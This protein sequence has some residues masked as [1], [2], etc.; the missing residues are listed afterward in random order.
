LTIL[1]TD[2]TLRPLTLRPAA[3]AAFA[4]RGNARTRRQDVTEIGVPDPV[5]PEIE[6]VPAVDPVPGPLEVPE[7]APAPVREPEPVPA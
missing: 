4:F 6:I 1:V 5:E 3:Q 2:P 7:P